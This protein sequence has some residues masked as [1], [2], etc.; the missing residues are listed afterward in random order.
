[1]PNF[2]TRKKPYCK[3]EEEEEEVEKDCI[4]A[5]KASF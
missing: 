2:T 3:Q 1:L 4:K 5:T